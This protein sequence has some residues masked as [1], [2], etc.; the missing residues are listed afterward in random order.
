MIGHVPS[1]RVKG[2]GFLENALIFSGLKLRM[3]AEVFSS[4]ENLMGIRRVTFSQLIEE[5]NNESDI[6]KKIQL[7]HRINSII[8]EQ[9]RLSTPSLITDDYIDTALF[10]IQRNMETDQ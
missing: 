6:D 1:K 3:N 7:F 9:Y 10:R 8:P 5:C 4:Q 2:N